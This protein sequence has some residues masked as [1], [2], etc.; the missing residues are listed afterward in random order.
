MKKFRLHPVL[1][2]VSLAG[3]SLLLA[4]D[5]PSGFSRKI[6]LEQDLATPGKHGAIAFIEFAA[7]AV[8][9]KH[10]HPGEELIYVI[11]GTVRIEVDGLAPRDLKAGDTMIIP[12]GVAHLGRN[13]GTAP[14]KI[15]S[16]YFLEKGQPLA[17]PAK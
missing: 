12:S 4:A 13:L 6:L 5:Q 2:L 16:S 7:G 17:S 15:V 11:E 1:F 8:A 9:P 3:V 14:A 10:F